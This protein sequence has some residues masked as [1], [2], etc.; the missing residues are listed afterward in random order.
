MLSTTT[1]H[2]SID[3]GKLRTPTFGIRCQNRSGRPMS[4]VTKSRHIT[5]AET[6]SISPSTAIS[7]IGFQL[8]T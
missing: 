8:Y 3:C 6:A 2:E 1:S 4:T 5:M 7:L